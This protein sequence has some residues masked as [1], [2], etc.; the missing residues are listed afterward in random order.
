MLLNLNPAIIFGISMI[1][2]LSLFIGILLV[3]RVIDRVKK[4]ITRKRIKRLT[5]RIWKKT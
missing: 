4:A 3:L 5:H 1:V 2:I